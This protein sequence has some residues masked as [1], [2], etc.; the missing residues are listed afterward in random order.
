M[1]IIIITAIGSLL[2]AIIFLAALVWSIKDEQYE[3]DFA[4]PN[5]ILFDDKTT[6]TDN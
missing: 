1:S 5:R 2:L 6:T 4:P 3:D